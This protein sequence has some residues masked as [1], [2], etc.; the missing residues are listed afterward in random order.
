MAACVNGV[1]RR[2]EAE[3]EEEKLPNTSALLIAEMQYNLF[4]NM[5]IQQSLC[6]VYQRDLLNQSLKE[7]GE[8]G[9]ETIPTIEANIQ[10]M[11]KG[12][13]EQLILLV[14]FRFRK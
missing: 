10:C 13:Q 4:R 1:E 14:F 12:S 2:E 6:L 7:K 9:R 11:H 5:Q 8:R 3:K